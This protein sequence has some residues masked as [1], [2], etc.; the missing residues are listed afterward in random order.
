MQ[1]LTP[2]YSI[3]GCDAPFPPN[4]NDLFPS[5]EEHYNLTLFEQSYSEALNTTNPY[6]ACFSAF[7]DEFMPS[8]DTADWNYRY[9]W[10]IK[11]CL[12]STCS[13]CNLKPESC[14]Q[15]VGAMSQDYPPAASGGIT[16]LSV[17]VWYNNQVLSFLI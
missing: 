11:N 16:Q 4:C 13:T 2:R 17:T 1:P 3:C 15:Y 9:N 14:H 6:I 8:C 5:L 12:P 10:L 7:T